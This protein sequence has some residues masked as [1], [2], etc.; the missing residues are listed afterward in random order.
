MFEVGLHVAGVDGK[1]LAQT[2]VEGYYSLLEGGGT[3]PIVVA[4]TDLSVFT[5]SSCTYLPPEI[6]PVISHGTYSFIG[7]TS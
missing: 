7:I 5:L 2:V 3:H 4:V 6:S 1:H